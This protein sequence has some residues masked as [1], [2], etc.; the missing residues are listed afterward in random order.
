MLRA[1]EELCAYHAIER[2]LF[3]RREQRKSSPQDLH[4]L[5]RELPRTSIAPMVLA[6][7]GANR[8]TVRAR[9]QFRSEGAW[10]NNTILPRHW[11]KVDRDVGGDAVE[12][13]CGGCMFGSRC[14][15]F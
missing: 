8:K 14:A 15:S 6:L 7:A 12:R 9:P 13:G 1:F 11:Q 3:R 5:L 2:P 10:E 4:S